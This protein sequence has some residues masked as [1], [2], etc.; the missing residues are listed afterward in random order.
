MSEKPF[1]E[2]AVIEADA[3]H[4]LESMRILCEH[5]EWNLEATMIAMEP[6]WKRLEEEV[7]DG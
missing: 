5:L 2:R 4:I 1:P 6:I 3:R 7:L